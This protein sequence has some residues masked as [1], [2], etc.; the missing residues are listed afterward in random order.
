MGFNNFVQFF[1]VFAFMACNSNKG[2]TNGLENDPLV[3]PYRQ[4]LSNLDSIKE[5]IDS[6]D[7][8]RAQALLYTTIN[9]HLPSYWIGTEWDF[10]GT[11]QTPKS[12]NI[13]CG[14]FLTT[15][16][17]QTGYEIKRVWMAQQA[18]SVLIKAYC[19]DIKIMSSLKA[20]SEY[21]KN[22]KD[23]SC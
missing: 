1:L 17:Q 3:I 2:H 7:W 21:L 19:S 16:M 9:A 23:S 4:C 14:Y 18:S 15:T 8:D 12:G 6:A 22:Q 13:A 5:N 20:V 11:T 10:N